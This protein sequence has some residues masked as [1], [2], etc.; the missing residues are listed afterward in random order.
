MESGLMRKFHKRGLLAGASLVGILALTMALGACVVSASS[1]LTPTVTVN[2]KL[3]LTVPGSIA[4]SVDP[5]SIGTNTVSVTAK[6]NVAWQVTAAKNTN[7]TST[8]TPADTI[9]SADFLLSTDTATTTVTD[10]QWNVATAV[11]LANARSAITS[12]FTYKVDLTNQWTIPAHAD[13]TCLHT[14]TLQAAP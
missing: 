13:Y 12:T 4:V 3:E 14:Y 2:Q 9:P 6:G 10:M 1:P 7:L 8:A 5:G 11:C